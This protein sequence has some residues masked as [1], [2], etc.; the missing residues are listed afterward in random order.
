MHVQ[1]AAPSCRVCAAPL[2]SSGLRARDRQHAL[3]GENLIVECLGCGVAWT[4][5]FAGDDEL[6]RFYPSETYA[7]YHQPGGR[8]GKLAFAPVNWWRFRGTPFDEVAARPPGRLFDVGC[9][10]GDLLASF[11]ERGWKVEGCDLSETAVAVCGE[12]GFG[13]RH[14]ALPDVASGVEQGAFDV[15]VYRHALEH[16]ND[17]L[18]DL[19]L[20]GGLLAP[21]GTI[22]V[23]MPNWD[24]WQRRL[25]GGRWFPLEMPRHRLHLGP[26]SLREV[27]RRAGLDVR[28]TR[29]G[30]SAL[31][32]P[33]SLQY[34]LTGRLLSDGGWRLALGYLV[35]VGLYPVTYVA[36]RIGGSGDFLHASL[37]LPRAGLGAQPS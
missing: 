14:G 5:P 9:G 8:L 11:A 7:P 35:A 22:L 25:F 20:A 17:P 32:L 15:V 37:E 34:V 24:S 16:V 4:L 12:R 2:G 33:W 21:G 6:G 28:W 18:R 26:A 30:T 13:V 1:N 27:A 3:G 19:R 23:S 31:G 29:T 10:R 36:G